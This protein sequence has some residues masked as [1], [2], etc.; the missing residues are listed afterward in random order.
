MVD[1]SRELLLGWTPRFVRVK[2][3]LTFRRDSSAGSQGT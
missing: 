1:D 2:K 3:L